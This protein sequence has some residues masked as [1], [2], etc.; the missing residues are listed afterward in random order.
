MAVSN[1]KSVVLKFISDMEDIQAGFKKFI[2]EQ[3]TFVL[4]LRI[5]PVGVDGQPFSMNQSSSA[6]SGYSATWGAAASG[7]AIGG[8]QHGQASVD[9]T[10]QRLYQ[11]YNQTGQQPMTEFQA[12]RQND[13]NFHYL[14]TQK[15][16]AARKNS[17]DVLSGGKG[18]SEFLSDKIK[19]MSGKND[20][21]LQG[22]ITALTGLREK[23]DQLTATIKSLDE[24]EKKGGMTPDQLTANRKA[25]E[26]AYRTQQQIAQTA[27]GFGGG[28]SNDPFN[29]LFGQ[30]KRAAT[31]I[32]GIHVGN[33]AAQGLIGGRGAALDSVATMAD[34]QMG[35]VNASLRLSPTDLLTTLDPGSRAYAQNIGYRGVLGSVVGGLAGAGTA[36]VAGGEV[37]GPWGAAAGVAGSGIKQLAS[38]IGAAYYGGH[39]VDAAV[40][41][42]MM[43]TLE[44]LAH[45]KGGDIA[46]GEQYFAR[47]GTRKSFGRAFGLKTDDVQQMS[48]HDLIPGARET[49]VGE[50]ATLNAMMQMPQFVGVKGISGR[51]RSLMRNDIDPSD[52]AKGASGLM[53]VAHNNEAALKTYEDV[54][55]RAFTRGHQNSPLAQRQTE[56]ILQMASR[57]GGFS[58]GSGTDMGERAIRIMGDSY[59]NEAAASLASGAMGSSM[60]RMNQ[61]SG[62]QGMVNILSAKKLVEKFM[63]KATGATKTA[64]MMAFARS[65]DQYESMSKEI[66]ESYEQAT[67]SKVEGDYKEWS[68]FQAAGVSKGENKYNPL[69]QAGVPSR[70]AHL[71]VDG[72]PAGEIIAED[73]LREG[74][75]G[76]RGKK[77]EKPTNFDTRG[78][79]ID[80]DD[81][82]V[83][84]MKA[85]EQ[86][87]AQLA[88]GG[89]AVL[90]RAF[91]KIVDP[92]KTATD[93]I[94]AMSNAAKGVL[95]ADGY[96]TTIAGPQEA[97]HEHE[98]KKQDASIK[99]LRRR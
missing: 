41:S 4:K 25:S 69:I 3:E 95:G 51:L 57:A 35:L 92:V 89:L 82:V 64:L 80:W 90:Q 36:G 23:F 40:A 56:A 15:A 74:F 73:V 17:M 48:I 22:T 54:M 9:L 94:I 70:L 67:G 71:A 75:I 44:K 62:Q 39:P 31:L 24:T 7:G 50:E 99:G 21:Q 78:E 46:M 60:G 26:D 97:L 61:R 43:A 5:Q 93:A 68:S 85:V 77:V 88:N 52:I 1:E 6:G 10:R 20:P 98:N 28:G 83:K 34:L 12:L 72:G 30:L 49:G 18:G 96:R 53:G 11:Q 42:T 91:E 33:A 37:A 8:G 59:G 16:I 47:A 84:Q 32:G 86:A 63:P 45:V 2:A 79:Y 38:P 27:S 87:S 66:A 14:E 81:P 76:G 19:E 55:S 65:P 29:E 58:G 13:S